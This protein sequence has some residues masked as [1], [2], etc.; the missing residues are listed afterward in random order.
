MLA[1]PALHLIGYDD[2]AARRR[3]RVRVLLILALLLLSALKVVQVRVGDRVWAAALERFWESRCLTHQ[4][5][6]DRVAFVA[7]PRGTAL[8]TYL[9]DFTG[10]SGSAWSGTVGAVPYPIEL[11]ELHRYSR[12]RDTASATIDLEHVP[13]PV[14]LHGLRDAR[15]H[16]WMVTVHALANNPSGFWTL[17]TTARDVDATSPTPNA[18][19]VSTAA[20]PMDN[21]LADTLVVFAGQ[22]DPNDPSKFS[23]HTVINKREVRITGAVGNDGKLTF[24]SS[25]GLRPWDAKKAGG[26][27]LPAITP[28]SHDGG[29]CI[30]VPVDD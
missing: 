4:L 24:T 22:P 18:L 6:I 20:W 8:P 2:P 23:L 16:E 27:T 29:A 21:T 1:R 3:R 11:A 10:A 15:G 26:L 12:T 28:P 14:F 13:G 17:V 9:G 5:P 30:L 7:A 25:D 19:V